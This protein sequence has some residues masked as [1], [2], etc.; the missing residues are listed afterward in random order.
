MLPCL[1]SGSGSGTTP[2]PLRKLLTILWPFLV[3]M[4]SGWNCTPCTGSQC[5]NVL[6]GPLPHPIAPEMHTARKRQGRQG[7]FWA[8]AAAALSIPQ[9]GAALDA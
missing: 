5:H 3:M 1:S 8:A 4:L 6:L 7:L 9:R 2:S